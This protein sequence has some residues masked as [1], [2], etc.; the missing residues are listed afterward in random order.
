MISP[1]EYFERTYSN[2]PSHDFVIIRF[3]FYRIDTTNDADGLKVTVDVSTSYSLTGM[4]YENLPNLCGNPTYTDWGPINI[5]IGMD[6]TA[7]SITLRFTNICDQDPTNESVGI[8]D[9]SIMFK[10]KSG[11]DITG[12][13]ASDG[14]K[15]PAQAIVIPCLTN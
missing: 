1:Q 9:L 4:P 10:S 6:H 7:T 12:V 8:R 3:K 13:W 5:W 15:P 14:N 11:K 2:L